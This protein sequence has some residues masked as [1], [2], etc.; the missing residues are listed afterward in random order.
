MSFSFIPKNDEEI[1]AIQNIALLEQGIYSFVVKQIEQQISKANNSMLEIR[2]GVIDK[3]GGERNIT[4]YLLATPQMIYKLKH[5]CEA[6]GMEDKYS[7]G[8]FEPTDFINRSGKVKIGIEK[9]APKKD[10]SGFYRDKNNVIDYI[11]AE[12]KSK[13]VEKIEDDFDDDIKF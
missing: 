5:F 12:V 6:I 4:D 13:N 11:K 3:D 1:N 9:G 7:E 10:G 2:I 8:S